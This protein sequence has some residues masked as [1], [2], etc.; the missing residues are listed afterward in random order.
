MAGRVDTVLRVFDD[1]DEALRELGSASPS[2]RA[3]ACQAIVRLADRPEARAAIPDLVRLLQ[4]P[5]EAVKASAAEALDA[6]GDPMGMR[7]LRAMADESAAAG[8][9]P[10]GAALKRAGGKEAIEMV[11]S[12][13][14]GDPQADYVWLQEECRRCELT[15]LED[16]TLE[17]CNGGESST[18]LVWHEAWR[19]YLPR[20]SSGTGREGR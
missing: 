2:R 7:Y 16:G 14:P 6:L 8:G 17:S 3:L 10:A 1:F 15:I 11:V 12:Q 13:R 4:D 19:K 20:G 18:S 5:N 9:G